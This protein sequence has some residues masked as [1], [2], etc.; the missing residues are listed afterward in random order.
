MVPRIDCPELN[1]GY[2]GLAPVNLATIMD[3]RCLVRERRVS[4]A[5]PRCQ[6]YHSNL[7]LQEQGIYYTNTMLTLKQLLA[8]YHAIGFESFDNNFGELRSRGRSIR[9]WGEKSS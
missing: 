1:N 5:S 3:M 9:Q 2:P 7:T 4:V 8:Q 6:G